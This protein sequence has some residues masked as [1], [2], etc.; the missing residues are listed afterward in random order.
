MDK[1]TSPQAHKQSRI[2]LFDFLLLSNPASLPKS[3]FSMTGAS[4]ALRFCCRS[5]SLRCIATWSTLL[6]VMASQLCTADDLVPIKV[7]GQVDLNSSNETIVFDL[8]SH[9]VGT[10]LQAELSVTNKTGRGI[11]VNVE[12]SCGCTNVSSKQFSADDGTT[13]KFEATVALPKTAQKFE[14]GLICKDPESRFEFTIA[15]IANCKSLVDLQPAKVRVA[16]ASESSTFE[17]TAA[18][19][20]ADWQIS[21]ATLGQNSV[22]K[23]LQTTESDGRFILSFQCD[24]TKT[25]NYTFS[26]LLSFSLVHSKTGEQRESADTLTIEFTDRIRIGPSLPQ[27]KLR[28]D[29]VELLIYLI[30]NDV[31]SLTVDHAYLT[32]S[33]TQ[34]KL[35][36]EVHMSANKGKVKV[37]TLGAKREDWETFLS[38]AGEDAF[39]LQIETRDRKTAR[40]AVSIESF[41]EKKR[42]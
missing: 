6:M 37:I 31:E 28:A 42:D 22:V 29:S 9:P 11:R 3:L 2:C 35:V 23:L 18:A 21:N 27:L 38:G 41:L 34:N 12:P 20:Q 36:F 16:N 19:T 7:R 30:A 4:L 14:T 13:I 17:V 32:N 24:P 39:Y 15:L 10:T 1:P 33:V 40:T 25:P 26:S 5:K 8:G